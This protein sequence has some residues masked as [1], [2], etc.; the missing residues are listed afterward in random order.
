MDS[1]LNRYG[2]EVSADRVAGGDGRFQCPECKIRVIHVVASGKVP[3]FRHDTHN[4]RPSLYE[5]CSRYVAD[6]GGPVTPAESGRPKPPARTPP[7]PRIVV[8]WRP[9]STGPERW[10]LYVSVPPLPDGVDAVWV[11]SNVNGERHEHRASVAARRTV[12]VRAEAR[13]YEVVGYKLDRSGRS[14][15]VWRPPP[16]GLL[17]THRPNVFEAGGSGGAQLA[18]TADLV[19]G[20]SYFALS[21]KPDVWQPPPGGR[22]APVRGATACDRNQEWEG[23]LF[24][25]PWAEDRAVTRWC[26]Q[27]CGRRLVYPPGTLSLVYPP[28]LDTHPDGTVVVPAGGEVVFSVAGGRW[29]E[30]EVEVWRE[31]RPCS[32]HVSRLVL[33]PDRVVVLGE[34]PPGVYTVYLCEWERAELRLEVCDRKAPSL[35]AVTVR[36]ADRSSSRELRGELHGPEGGLRWCGLMSGEEAWAGVEFPAGWPVTFGWRRTPEG[37][38]VRS[39][40]TTPAALGAAVGEAL[41]A[42]PAAARIDAGPFGA[43]DWA[44]PPREIDTRPAEVHLPPAT[45]RR[46]DW[47]LKTRGAGRLPA[48][49]PLGVTAPVG[50]A[51]R[52]ADRDRP[53][54]ESFFRAGRWPTQL[55]AHARALAKDLCRALA[56]GVPT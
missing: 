49:I 25:L 23:H 38:E 42:G 29:E 35:P 2:V 27:V 47:L 36:T 30:P 33:G 21:S 51:V 54:V 20:R 31:D 39:V 12:P 32:P 46:L 17:V 13:Q 37:D 41:G 18:P 16:T 15:P 22:S 44:T 55:A 14:A 10:V 11:R 45:I 7:S 6:R 4:V 26:E 50:W 5:H 28:R 3:Y 24:Y 9:S 1:A 19:R 52:V 48:T 8:G 53:T 40:H 56:P 43:V 34:L